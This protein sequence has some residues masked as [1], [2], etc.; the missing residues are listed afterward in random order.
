MFPVGQYKGS[1]VEEVVKE[2]PDY[3]NWIQR[4]SWFKRNYPD[5]HRRIVA[6][7]ENEK[8]MMFHQQYLE[9]KKTNVSS[10]NLKQ[11][12]T[13]P[14]W[15]QVLPFESKQFEMLEFKLSQKLKKKTVYP[16]LPDIFTAF[17]LCPLDQVKVIICGQDP[18]IHEDEAHGL[19]FSVQKHNPI[20]PSLKNI[21]RE[22]GITSKSGDLSTWAERGVLLLNSILTV[23]KGKSGSHADI[24]WQDFCKCA[25]QAVEAHAS[26]H[27]KKLAI[28]LW[29]KSAQEFASG[30]FKSPHLILTTSH[31]SPYSV[32]NG[33]HGCQHFQKVS[34]FFQPEGFDWSL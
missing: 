8:K 16:P 7:L 26:K 33:F 22:A 1:D 11:Y 17:N 24:G 30:I 27:G 15:L 18:Y 10:L 3:V 20:P 28:L 6:L 29:G 4:Q 32:N 25:L 9:M 31:P 13:R 5:I 21:F 19:A 23:D 2:D 34:E 14:S 12:L